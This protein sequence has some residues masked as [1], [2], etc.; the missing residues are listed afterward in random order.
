MDLNGSKHLYTTGFYEPWGSY[1]GPH[2]PRP[3]EL[4][5]ESNQQ[6]IERSCHE[7]LGLTKMSFNSAA[8]FGARPITTKMAKEVGLIMGELEEGQFPEPS[9]RYYM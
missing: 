1:P 3:I 9:Y 8:P 4:R 2:V 5:R 7:I 6:Q